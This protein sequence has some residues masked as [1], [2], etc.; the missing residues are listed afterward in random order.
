AQRPRRSRRVR[1]AEPEPERVRGVQQ[2]RRRRDGHPNADN[3]TKF[4]LERADGRVVYVTPLTPY[5]A[6]GNVVAYLEDV[7]DEVT[8]DE[9]PAAASTSWGIRRPRCR[10]SP[11]RSRRCTTRTSTGRR[12]TRAVTTRTRHACSS[13]PRLPAGSCR[14]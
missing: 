3:P 4:V 13:S 2:R 10:P 12:P 14:R 1:P 9:M 6:S 8:T 7:A 5:G 11:R